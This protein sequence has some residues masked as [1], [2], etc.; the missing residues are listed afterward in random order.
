MSDEQMNLPEAEEQDS[1]ESA[2]EHQSKRREKTVARNVEWFINDCLPPLLGGFGGVGVIGF[3]IHSQ[4]FE[5]IVT[6]VVTVVVASWAKY[7]RSFTKTISTIAGKRGE[8]DAK[9]LAKGLGNGVGILVEA[10]KWQFSGF[11]G[12]YLKFQRQKLEDLETEGFNRAEAKTLQLQEVFVPSL[13][14]SP[15]DR[16]EFER[17]QKEHDDY[18]LNI[19]TLLRRS[20]KETQC[21]EIVIQARGGYG[22]TTLLQHIALIYSSKQYRKRKFRTVKRIPFLLRLRD[23]REEM[24]QSTIVSLPK[25]IHRHHLRSL[26]KKGYIPP[27]PHWA[28]ILLNR[29]DALVMLD[30]FDEVPSELREKVSHWITEQMD[31]YGESAF[32]LTSRPVAYQEFYTARRPNYPITVQRFTPEQQ[33]TFARRWYHCVEF[34]YRTGD[35]RDAKQKA[36]RKAEDLCDDFLTQLRSRPEMEEMAQIPLL[37]NLL[38]TYHRSNVTRTLPSQRLELYGGICK[39]QLVDRPFARGVDMLVRPEKAMDILRR[40]AWEM[41]LTNAVELTVKRSKLLPF[42]EKQTALQ[43]QN[44]K[45]EDFLSKIVE[46]SE[47]LVERE[48]GEYEFPHTSFHGFFAAEALSMMKEGS[49]IVLK[50]WLKSKESPVWQE[51]IPFFTSQLDERPFA[52][53]IRDAL[54]LGNDAVP[55]AAKCL[56]EYRTTNPKLAQ[57]IMALHGILSHSR[58]ARLEQLLKVNQ[59]KEA[60]LETNRVMLEVKDK[61]TGDYL[62]AEDMETFPCE[63]LLTIDRLWVEASNRHF[64]FSVQKKIWERFGSLYY[65]EKFAESVGWGEERSYW[66]LKFSIR[67][68]PRGELPAFSSFSEEEIYEGGIEHLFSRAATCGL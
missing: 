33:A 36:E 58:Y 14:R 13:L 35:S 28:E 47:L 54:S 65:C 10:I 56:N 6:S 53:I 46:V 64:G 17:S 49:A 34:G 66:D 50:H 63:D 48:A 45:A 25:L 7:S 24:S 11:T 55:M 37:L 61:D 32:I 59:W 5:A 27:T 51:T 1:E 40:I 57:E 30:G 9:S 4:V 22:K 26:E 41:L 2:I 8:Q 3:M 18:E 16:Q 21:R 62:T 42:L 19:W 29:G 20:K 12:Q 60:D 44:V 31:T 23:Y 38:I 15:T 43:D 39:L 68:S 67:N 52:S